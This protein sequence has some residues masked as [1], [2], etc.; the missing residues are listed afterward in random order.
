MQT[1][2][3]CITHNKS[4]VM[5]HFNFVC[6]GFPL[7]KSNTALHINNTVSFWGTRSGFNKFSNFF[8]TSVES[9]TVNWAPNKLKDV[10]P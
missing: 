3:I 1:S 2:T 4:C 5:I 6:L 9:A 10:E 8:S 7:K